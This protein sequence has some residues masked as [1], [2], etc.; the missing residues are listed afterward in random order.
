MQMKRRV[1]VCVAVSLVLGTNVC[2]EEVGRW[3]VTPQAGGIVTDDD[4]NIEDGDELVGLS[5]GKH[6]S[7][8]WSVE[9]NANGANL[10]AFSP[11]AASLDVLRVFRRNERVS[12][13]LTF[14]AGALRNDFDPGR[15]DTDAMAQAGVGLLWQ[16]GENR[17][18][19]SAFSLRPEIKARW[20]DAGR[21]DF[22]D[23]IGTLGFQFSF[24]AAP[25]PVAQPVAQEPAPR[26]APV[27]APVET[28]PADSDGDGVLDP[29]DRCPGTPRGV[30]VDER[31]CTQQG[32]ITLV[33][34]NFETNSATLT[35]DSHAVLDRLAADLRK[36]PG[37]QIEL[38]G[39]T[40]S[41]GTDQYNLNLSERRA[42]AVREY[43]MAQGVAS[44]Q[45]QARGYGE[46]Q[47]IAG[48]ATADGRAQNR[49]VVLKVLQNPGS[50]EI[51]GEGQL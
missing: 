36:Y 19:T 25:A 48:N 37:L 24:G 31:G 30:A 7:E 12:P 8:R 43:L 42:D 15:D 6:I 47:P 50:V 14:G 45:V 44:S 22:I 11:Y 9:L 10:D 2:A 18:G 35:H 46:S 13:Y 27:P 51:K 4:R 16:L 39:H 26:P 28:A 20:D 33:G 34:V 21:E 41:S 49:R 5:I 1:G 40:D 23:Y 38:Q 17:R 29:N 32:E 3:Y